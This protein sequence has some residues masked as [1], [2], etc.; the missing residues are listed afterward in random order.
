MSVMPRR[1]VPW[2]LVLMLAAL[3]ASPARAQDQGKVPVI[4]FEGPEVFC[5]LLHNR[6]LAPVP[7]IADLA[8][9]DPKQT[10]VV[11]FGRTDAIAQVPESRE[12][13]AFLRDGG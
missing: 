6:K 12:L 4:P 7:A 9:C 11:L 3:P 10:L 1:C 13:S 5:Y 2:L 8:D